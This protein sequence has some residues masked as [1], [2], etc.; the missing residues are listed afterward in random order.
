M[1]V[2]QKDRLTV[3][4]TYVQYTLVLFGG[5]LYII[6]IRGSNILDNLHHVENWPV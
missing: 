6:V 1:R 3:I 2:I 4:N 5:I